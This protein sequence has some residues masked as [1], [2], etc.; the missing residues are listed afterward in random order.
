[1]TNPLGGEATR[2][3]IVQNVPAHATDI[4]KVTA[5][6]FD[7]SRQAVH[8]HVQKLIEDG[9]LIESGKTRNKTYALAP[10]A[11]F[12]KVYPVPSRID[13]GQVWNED[14]S[15]A[16]GDM[17]A[18][19]LGIWHYGFTEL[20]NN[21]LEHSNASQLTVSFCKNAAYSEIKIQDNGVG[22]FKKIQETLNLYDERHAAL[23]LAKGKFTTDPSNHSGEGI[24]F[25][26]RMFDQFSITSGKAGLLSYFEN[27]KWDVFEAVNV[28]NG[29][30]V[31]IK[32]KND[33]DRTTKN[34]FDIFSIGEDYEF[35]K[36]IIPVKLTQYGDDNLVSRS[37]AKRLLARIDKFKTVVFDFSGVESI[38]QSFADEVFRVFARRH[39]GI[40][41][42]SINTSKPVEQ[43]ISRALA[44][45][46]KQG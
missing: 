9:A 18:N 38:G 39:P 4:I 40:S 26:S 32:L 36:T 2:K 43:M 29:T 45:G 21:A 22:V 15:P 13:E 41:M 34:I 6:Q 12:E 11:K 17:A 23:E 8:K 24:F 44:H 35:T 28:L 5:E 27:T 7:C 19:I 1:M 3:F 37:Q 33:T 14:I 25:S 30:L 10:L 42:S 31:Y 46:L 20:F 16:L